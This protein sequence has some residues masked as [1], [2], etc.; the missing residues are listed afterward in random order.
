M[1]NVVEFSHQLLMQVK[2]RQVAIDMT[3]GNGY[4][5]LF[6][7]KTVQKVYAFDIQEEAIKRTRSLLQENNVDNVVLLKES[8]D[9]YDIFVSEPI[10]M[11]IYNLGYLPSGNKDIK[12][13]AKIVMNSLKKALKQLNLFGK[14]VIVIYL[15]DL[16]ESIRLSEFTSSLG[17]E[18][19]VMKHEV[20]NKAS[21]PYI[22]EI[23]K[24]KE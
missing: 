22:I 20:L 10:D 24:I 21:S 7:A 2:N 19:D 5:T 11:A 12:T 18:Y 3:A 15:H 16:D 9:L 8:H 17:P 23:S 14:I 4:D 6:L 1:I 13:D